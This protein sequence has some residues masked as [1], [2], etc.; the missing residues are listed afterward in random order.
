M[1]GT[2]DPDFAD[3]VA[4]AEYLAE[5]IRGRVVMIKDAGHYPQTEMPDTTAQ[6]VVEFLKRGE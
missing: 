5:Q 1:M 2:K 4:E 3:P 6:A